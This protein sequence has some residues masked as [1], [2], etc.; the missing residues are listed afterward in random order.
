MRSRQP[1]QR[2]EDLAQVLLHGALG[3]AAASGGDRVEDRRMMHDRHLSRQRVGNAQETNAVHLALRLLDYLPCVG[4]VRRA[5]EAA[6]KRV[7]EHEESFL[8]VG[9]RCLSLRADDGAAFVY[10]GFSEE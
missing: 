5:R 6:M 8:I 10:R 9:A 3:A 2:F 4:A 7:V 1:R